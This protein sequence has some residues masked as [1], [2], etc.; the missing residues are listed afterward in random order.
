MLDS[1]RMQK[2]AS[3][4][5]EK[6]DQGQTSGGKK[7]PP[8]SKSLNGSVKSL[9]MDAWYQD[10]ETPGASSGNGFEY[11]M[12][13]EEDIGK[14]AK[15]EGEL[16]QVELDGLAYKDTKCFANTMRKLDVLRKSRQL[17]DL[18]LQLDND[19]QD[20]YCHQI[21]L[22]CNSKFFMEIF[23]NYEREHQDG[24][25]QSPGLFNGLS[26][27]SAPTTPNSEI[28]AMRKKSVVELVNR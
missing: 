4:S 20:I 2:C 28:T 13:E 12:E 8:S 14:G 21:V 24:A 15:G 10:L 23:T 1:A 17:C 19:S 9:R 18:V 25:A 6:C 27:G 5:P 11:Y 7:Q 26:N 3:E 22:A 16:G